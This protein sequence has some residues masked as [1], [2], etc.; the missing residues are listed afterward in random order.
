MEEKMENLE[1]IIKKLHSEIK[2]VKSM[3]NLSDLKAEYLGKKGSITL[4]SSQIKDI[5]VEKRKEF[6]ANLNKYKT[7]A[8]DLF[9]TKLQEINE[10]ILT[11]KLNQ[12]A[13]DISLPAT[14]INVGVPHIIEGVI[15][16]LEE[17]LMSMGYDVVEG[18]ELEQ[19][20]YNFE[21]LNLPKGH[22]ALDAQDTFYTN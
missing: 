15:E 20:L 22:P 6:G 3:Q 5:P 4:L 12:E 10:A 8:E 21:L 1:E 13:I 19:D 7:M 16:E 18:P 9:N 11:A 14:K 17:L 2:N